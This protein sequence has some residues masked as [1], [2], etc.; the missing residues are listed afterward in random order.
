VLH[1]EV[2][3]GPADGPATSLGRVDI[4]N[5]TPGLDDRA[6][7]ADYEWAAYQGGTTR[8]ATPYATGVVHGHDRSAGWEPLVA[9]VL[10]DLG[11]RRPKA[12]PDEI[13]R[14]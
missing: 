8:I 13:R 7:R 2:T 9:A 10:A 1:V 4:W 14:C 3:I 6:G 11:A 12:P 5:V